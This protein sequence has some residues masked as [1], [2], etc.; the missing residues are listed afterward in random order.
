M[1]AIVAI[2]VV[3]ISI[4]SFPAC[5][6]AVSDSVTTTLRGGNNAITIPIPSAPQLRYQSTDFVGKYASITLSKHMDMERN[7]LLA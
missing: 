4:I 6:A 5:G 3:A 2:A 7:R 1:V